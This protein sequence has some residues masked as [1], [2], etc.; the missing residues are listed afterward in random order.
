MTK[1]AGSGSV[2]QWYESADPDPYVPQS[3]V[4]TKLLRNPANADV[5]RQEKHTEMPEPDMVH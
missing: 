1:K 5:E 2:S 4:S 3:H